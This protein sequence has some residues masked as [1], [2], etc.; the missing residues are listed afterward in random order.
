MDDIEPLQWLNLLEPRLQ[1]QAE[2]AR[3]YDM[4]YSGERELDIVRDE[5]NQVFGLNKF[6]PPRTNVAAVGVNAVAERLRVEGF[7][8]GDE[9]N[10]DGARAA[11]DLWRRNELD[12]MQQIAN[13]ESLAKGTAF[14]LAWPDDDGNAVI[15]VEDAEQMVVAR[16]SRPPYDVIAALKVYTDEWTGDDIAVLYLPDG[17]RTYKATR[18]AVTTIR[19]AV[20]TRTSSGLILPSAAAVD[21]VSKAS[22]WR[23]WA[24]NRGEEFE[25]APKGLDGDIP[26]VELTNRAR[27]LRPAQSALVD[28]APLADTHSKV[29]ADLVIACSF[30]AVPI[31]TATGVSL[32]RDASGQLIRDREGKIPSPYDVRADRAMV[33]ENPNAKFGTLPAADL[34][35]YVAARDAV[36][37]DI[38]IVT[39][40]PQHYYGQGVSSGMSGETLKASEASLVRLVDGITPRHGASYR[41][42]IR[43]GF[44]IEGS[45]F[46]TESIR[47]RWADTETRV[48][49]QLIDG[50]TKLESIG[51]PLELI[52]TE[53][54]KMPREV[55]ARAMKMRQQEA[56]RGEA[57]LRALRDSNVGAPGAVG[58]A[59]ALPAGS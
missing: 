17:I 48:E 13:V 41:K 26:V 32:A 10:Q 2:H 39:R 30:G 49:A 18:T 31:R 1:E 43:Y 57:I 8:V 47:T 56:L 20:S 33:S 3:L 15:S 9:E 19:K 46:A 51:V 38:R 44:A 5:Y 16:E 4:H 40:V 28:V 55:V 6:D 37:L 25:R 52:L 50:A 21:R 42:I 53:H 24:P 35:G 14:L 29:M 12:E 27:L 54:L 36:L 58:T 7:I 23:E 45:R 11:S 59:P 22:R 34:A